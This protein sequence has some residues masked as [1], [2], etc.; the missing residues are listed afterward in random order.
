MNE[1]N[2]VTGYEIT[3]GFDSGQWQGF[4]FP[5]RT[6]MLSGPHRL[7]SSSPELEFPLTVKVD[8]A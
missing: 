7:L 4:V 1:Y 3:T 5:S 6:E 2:K 8:E